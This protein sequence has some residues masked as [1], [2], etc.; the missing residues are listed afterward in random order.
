MVFTLLKELVMVLPKGLSS[1]L[2]AVLPPLIKVLSD[3]ASSS[4]L[5]C[6]PQPKTINPKP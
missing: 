3:K 4:N 6:Y 2:D 5:R 1:H